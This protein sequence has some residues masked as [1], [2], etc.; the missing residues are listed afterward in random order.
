MERKS[1]Y[2]LSAMISFII[3]VLIVVIFDDHYMIRGFV[4]DVVVITL[5]YSTVKIFMDVKAIALCVYV[6]LFAYILEVLQ[7]FRLIEWIGLEDNSMAK[8]IIGS[9]F[10]PMDLLAYT[11]GFLFTYILE[12]LVF[13]RLIE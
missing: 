7:Y 5:V 2:S 1:V 8:I 11:L 12:L 4:G 13:K 9:T 10:D 6:L 3:C